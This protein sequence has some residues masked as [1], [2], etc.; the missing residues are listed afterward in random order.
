MEFS[1]ATKKNDNSLYKLIQVI[2]KIYQVKRWKQ[3]C[4]VYDFDPK[5]K[6]KRRKEGKQAGKERKVIN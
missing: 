5:K 1:A 4:T 3:V 6:Q 2:T